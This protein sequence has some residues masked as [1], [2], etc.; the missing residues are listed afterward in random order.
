MVSDF[1]QFLLLF[2]AAENNVLGLKKNMKMNVIC[3]WYV[4]TSPKIL[5]P[6]VLS[7]HTFRYV[8]IPDVTACYEVSFDFIDLYS[9]FRIK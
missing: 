3:A 2:I 8:D 7:I 5:R 9:N 6:C 4:I 1:F